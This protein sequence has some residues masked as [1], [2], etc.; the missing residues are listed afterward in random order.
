MNNMKYRLKIASLGAVF[1]PLCPKLWMCDEI[2][3]ADIDEGLKT[4]V[5][6]TLP[7]N[8]YQ[9]N[10]TTALSF[11]FRDQARPYHIGRICH[12]VREGIERNDDFP[13]VCS[14]VGGERIALHEGRHRTAAAFVRG[15][16]FITAQVSG[17]ATDILAAV[18]GSKIVW[19]EAQPATRLRLSIKGILA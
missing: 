13:V 2:T 6:E 14:L 8:V 16:E 1:N 9:R 15:D 4:G 12:F 19:Q 5:R 7:W 17:P 18:P 10:A 3:R 11:M